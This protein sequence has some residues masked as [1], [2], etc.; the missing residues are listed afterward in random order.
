LVMLCRKYKRYFSLSN[1][2][3]EDELHRK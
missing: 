2:Q 3:Q 1:K